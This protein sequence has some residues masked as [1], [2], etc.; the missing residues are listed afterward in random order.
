LSAWASYSNH[1]E[2]GRAGAIEETIL[3]M[4]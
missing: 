1:L 2:S 4:D 3:R